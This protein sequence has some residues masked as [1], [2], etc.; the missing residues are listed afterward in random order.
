[1]EEVL[2][3]HK[4][5][6]S[7]HFLIALIKLPH[8]VRV[9]AFSCL[10][11]MGW[12][13]NPFCCPLT[14]SQ[15]KEMDEED[16]IP[17]LISVNASA[18]AVSNKVVPVTIVTGFLGSGKTTMIM[19]LLNDPKLNK[20]IAV[21]LNE[22]GESKG[23]DKSLRMGSDGTITE[24]WLEL[25]NGCLCCSVKDSGVKA[26]E[27]LVKRRLEFDYILVLDRNVSWKRQA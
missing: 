24:E 5:I 25:S 16:D 21:I 15:V 3:R 7:V 6:H 22:F 1:M 10:R 11:L 27:E 18:S 20:R 17:D 2:S 19:S 26:I 12:S 8:A 9:R 4:S 14:E 13:Q 23:I